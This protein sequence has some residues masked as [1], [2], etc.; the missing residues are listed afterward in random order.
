MPSVLRVIHSISAAVRVDATNNVIAR[1]DTTIALRP[2]FIFLPPKKKELNC[3]GDSI[4][5]AAVPTTDGRSREPAAFHP[6]A[7]GLVGR[8]AS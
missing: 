5:T 3:S 2:D 6:S 1:H 4:R 8:S 7:T